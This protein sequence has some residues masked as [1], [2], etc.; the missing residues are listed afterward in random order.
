M[1]FLQKRKKCGAKSETF[2]LYPPAK[3][4]RFNGLSLTAEASS[5]ATNRIA[6]R[7]EYGADLKAS[8]NSSHRAERERG[9]RQVGGK[10]RHMFKHSAR[11]Q[12]EISKPSEILEV[13]VWKR[14]NYSRKSV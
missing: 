10:S 1:W 12:T 6:D 5:P 11:N 3:S 8:N 9:R 2:F 13:S 14:E 4:Q 7:L